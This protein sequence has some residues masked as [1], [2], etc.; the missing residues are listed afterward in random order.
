MVAAAVMAA[1]VAAVQPDETL[2]D[3]VDVPK[4]LFN[5]DIRPLLSDRC[6]V[7]H[8]PDRSSEDAEATDGYLI[9][10]DEIWDPVEDLD[11]LLFAF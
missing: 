8:G 1:V 3:Q 2:A 9:I 6:F 11:Y 5:R 10:G 4:V 7:C